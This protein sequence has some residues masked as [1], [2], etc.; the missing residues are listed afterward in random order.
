MDVAS[1]QLV[2]SVVKQGQ[3]VKGLAVLKLDQGFVGLVEVLWQDGDGRVVGRVVRQNVKFPS[4]QTIRFE[5]K[6]DKFPMTVV[7]HI[8]VQAT[9]GLLLRRARSEARF[10][11][12]PSRFVWDDYQIIAWGSRNEWATRTF[13]D[14]LKQTGI[15]GGMAYATKPGRPRSDTEW[16]AEGDLRFYVENVCQIGWDGKIKH[17]FMQDFVAPAY[18]K[19]LDQP[20]DEKFLA[21][22]PCLND[23]DYWAQA[24]DRIHKEIE[25]RDLYGPM[26]YNIGDEQSLAFF[27]TPYD[28]CFSQHCLAQFRLWL[29]KQY[30]RLDA[31]N[32]AWETSFESWESVRPMTREVIRARAADGSQ[33]F[34]PWADH[35]QFMDQTMADLVERL[36]GYF[37]ERIPGAHVGIEGTQKPAIY[38]GFDYWRLMTIPLSFHE[39]YDIGGSHRIA[40]SFNMN[41]CPTLSLIGCDRDNR[42][43]MWQRLFH[44]DRGSVLWWLPAFHNADGT[45]RDVVKAQKDSWNEFTGGIAKLLD[46]NATAHDGVAIH[47]SPASAR[48]HWITMREIPFAGDHEITNVSDLERLATMRLIED[49]GYCYKFVAYEQVEKGELA[50]FKALFLAESSALSDAEADGIRKFVR[51]GGLVIADYMTGWFD[52]HCRRRDAGALDDVFGITRGD[53]SLQ[54]FETTSTRTQGGYWFEHVPPLAGRQVL[55]TR[56]LESLAVISHRLNYPTVE[57]TLAATTGA[58]VASENGVPAMIVNRYGKGLAVYL[59]FRLLY[60]SL[61]RT[62]KQQN[63]ATTTASIFRQILELAGVKPL[64]QASGPQIERVSFVEGEA[65]YHCLR[66]NGGEEQAGLGELAENGVDVSKPVGVS[67]KVDKPGHVYELRTGQYLGRTDTARGKLAHPEPLIY[68]VLPYRVDGVDLSAA[69]TYARGDRVRVGIELFT[70]GKPKFVRHVIRCRLYGPDSMERTGARRNLVTRTGKGGYA[71]D[72]A[73]NDMLGE[74]TVVVR[75]VATGI[76]RKHSFKLE[77]HA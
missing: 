15:T 65:Q 56:N 43:Q 62:A 58:A 11:A 45:A 4:T 12:T 69:A 47:Y 35:R 49:M 72:L 51:A 71:F 34:A 7:N 21:R 41:R 5:F 59:N 6:L 44:G 54:P 17:Q 40:Q 37:H 29:R 48:A 57:A 67:I 61:H 18:A 20:P 66:R 50:K 22:Q 32:A 33:S 77:P 30:R 36:I 38:G 19:G 74:W 39:I 73:I 53:F 8:V 76:E 31:M 25:A 64:A 2:Q 46:I 55:L 52:Q 27:T 60:Y 26:A 9:D 70:R 1:V 63:W 42:A 75:D 14:A 68:S 10:V 24:R 13:M 3:S 28:F 16:L 23:P